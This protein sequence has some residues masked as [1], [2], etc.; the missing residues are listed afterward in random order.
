[1]KY[2]ISISI[3]IFIISVFMSCG[4][5]KQINFLK[6]LPSL[7]SLMVYK[8]KTSFISMPVEVSVTYIENQINKK[9]VGLIFEDQNIEDNNALVKVWKTSAIKLTEKNGIIT[10]AIPLKVWIK[11][12]YGTAFLGLNDTKEINL[13]GI[14]IIESKAELSNWKLTT[15]SKI[16]DIKWN[17]SPN[18]VVAGKSIPITYII[19]PALSL[20]KTKIAAMIDDSIDQSCD[21]K[22]HVLNALNSISKP[23]LTSDI[24]ETWFKLIPIELYA[25]DATIKNSTIFMNLGLKCDMQ[26]MVGL[27]PKNTFDVSKIA[28]KPVAKMP[29]KITASVAA[30]STYESAS[31]IITK[32]FKGQVFGAGSKKVSI[33]NVEI[34][35]KDKKL[36][37]A[38][39]MTGAINGTV[40]LSGIPKYSTE[41]YEITFDDLD[42]VLDTKNVLLKS[43]NWLAQGK[44]LKKIKENCRYSIKENLDNGKK[45][46][47]PY[48]NNYSPI[49]GV[50]VNGNLTD[51]VFEK[52]ELTNKAIIAFITTSG[53]MS[54]TIDAVK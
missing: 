45:N 13:D 31:K 9:L 28:L 42:Y 2:I 32:N 16:I 8:N 49:K 53:N 41:T 35:E 20:F 37:I 38:L 22:P 26:T 44:I 12:K 25:T 6:P 48:L 50:F 36:I 34:W 30:V 33:Q 11:F 29:D 24:Y 27:E 14:V 18:I 21:F 52:I 43:A 3:F 47:Q 40:Y 1:M 4:T 51:F 23:F 17:E 7:N 54:I 15:T 5:A 39:S 46:M 19:K 10:S